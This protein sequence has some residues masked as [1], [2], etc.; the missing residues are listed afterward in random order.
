MLYKYYYYYFYTKLDKPYC[1]YICCPSKSGLTA[2]IK[3]CLR[4]INNKEKREGGVQP[5][6]D[7]Q[8]NHIRSDI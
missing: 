8:I 3:C 2:C 5:K 1:T 7:E 6:S 4:K